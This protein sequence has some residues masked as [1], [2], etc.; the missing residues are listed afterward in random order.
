MK[1][2][3]IKIR[4][5]SPEDMPFIKECI[6]RFHFTTDLPKYFK[7]LGFKKKGVVLGKQEYLE[8]AFLIGK[9]LNELAGYQNE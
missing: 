1:K 2:L 5:A 6:E 7:K 9:R 8:K 3:S 4:K